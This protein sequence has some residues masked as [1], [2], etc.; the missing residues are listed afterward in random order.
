MQNFDSNVK[1]GYTITH[2]ELFATTWWKIEEKKLHLDMNTV[3][4]ELFLENF[5][6]HFLP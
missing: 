5:Y 2:L 3:T 1:E 6:D 4:L